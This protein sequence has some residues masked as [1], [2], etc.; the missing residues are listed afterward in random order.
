VEAILGLSWICHNKKNPS[1]PW[2]H[3]HREDYFGVRI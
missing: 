2:A 1:S 3:E